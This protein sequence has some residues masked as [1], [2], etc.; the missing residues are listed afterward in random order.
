SGF[1]EESNV[2]TTKNMINMISNARE[3][4]MQMKTLSI[5]DKN[6]EYANQLLDVNN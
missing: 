5:F 6:S 4:E 2:S 3:F 1:L